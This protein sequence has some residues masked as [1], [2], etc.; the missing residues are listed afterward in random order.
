MGKKNKNKKGYKKGMKKLRGGKTPLSLEADRHDLYQRSVQEPEADVAFMRESFQKEFGRDPK[1][2]REDFCGTGFL[3]C[4]WVEAENDFQAFGVD[5]DP[6]PLQWGEVTNVAK[7]TEEQKKRVELIEGDALDIMPRKADVLCAL[8]FS[9]W[10]FKT[11]KT[12]L[13]YFRAVYE[14]IGE[15]GLFVLDIYGGPELTQLV[16]EEQEKDGFNYVWDQDYSDGIT[17]ELL[18]HIHFRFPDGSEM[19]RAFSYDW[20]W[21]SIPETREALV[22]AGFKRAEVYWEGDDEDE[23]SEEGN[24]EFTLEETAANSEAWIAYIVAVK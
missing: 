24:G 4:T 21:W 16:E 15:E 19:E 22:D 20:R 5:L 6:D 12:L 10:I 17:N 13:E 9:W 3:S 1:T 23:D 8:N 2:M 7:L 18:T 14:N 11:R